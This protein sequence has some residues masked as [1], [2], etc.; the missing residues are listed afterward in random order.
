M[1]GQRLRDRLEPLLEVAAEPRPRQ[2]GGGVERE[3]LRAG[4]PR[5]HVLFRQPRREPFGERGLAD[6]RVA[7]EHGVVLAP[8]AQDL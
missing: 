2:Q 8:P 5:R 3:H 1:I 6:A 4:Q 7:D